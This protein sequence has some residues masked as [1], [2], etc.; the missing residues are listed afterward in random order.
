M[1]QVMLNLLMNSMDAFNEK[2][3]GERQIV[4]KASQ[5][6]DGMVELAFIDNGPGIAPELLDSLFEPFVTTKANGTGLGLAISKN[7]V[8]LLGGD[9]SAENNPRIGATFRLTLPIAGQ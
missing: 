8:E 9:L 6:D 7:I 5:T 1:Q 4:I 2:P 3:N